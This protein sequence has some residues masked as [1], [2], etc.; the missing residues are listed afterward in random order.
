MQWV[1]R[2]SN[3]V[4]A[5]KLQ[6]ISREVHEDIILMGASRCHHHYIPSIISDSLHMS[7][8]NAGIGGANNIYSHYTVLRHILSRHVPKVVC[9]E[10]MPSDYNQQSDPFAVLS[11]FAPLFG[12]NADADSI[13]HL[14]N[15]YWRYQLSHLYRYNAKAPSN[16]WGLL[17]NRQN[18]SQ[19]G[20]TPLPRPSSFPKVRT[21]E[22]IDTSVDTLKL[23]YIRRF[24][25]L[26]RENDIRLIFTVSP[27]YT[28]V[29]SHH[30]DILRRLASEL[31]IPFLDYHTPGLYSDHP[32]YFKDNVHL[33]HEGAQLFSSLFAHDLQQALSLSSSPMMSRRALSPSTFRSLLSHRRR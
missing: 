33:W 30:Y 10:V 4:I 9:L 7:V 15:S 3:D 6:Y 1:N 26:C 27:K 32:E 29:S 11:F 17:L 18:D 28:E 13:F 12:T 31:S 16:L 21:L 14:N 20:Y 25:H 24:A 8:Y 23:E 19:Q 22:S 5:P 2:H